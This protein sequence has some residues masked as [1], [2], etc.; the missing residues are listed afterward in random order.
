MRK[1]SIREYLETVGLLTTSLQASVAVKDLSAIKQ[2]VRLLAE[3]NAQVK[4]A[5]HD[6][7]QDFHMVLDALYGMSTELKAD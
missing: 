4:E 1:T 5:A 3:A 6:F 7:D 2:D